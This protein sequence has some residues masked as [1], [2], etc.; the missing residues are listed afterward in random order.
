VDVDLDTV[1]VVLE[2][3]LHAG[4]GLR[5]DGSGVLGSI[6]WSELEWLRISEGSI[7]EL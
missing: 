2:D 6:Y 7:S 3:L 5:H 4:V 1:L